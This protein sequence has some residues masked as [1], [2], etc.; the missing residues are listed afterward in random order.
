MDLDYTASIYTIHTSD[1]A[2][3]ENEDSDVGRVRRAEERS[4]GQKT[5]GDSRQSTT[6]TVDQHAGQRPC[7][8]H[9]KLRYRCLLA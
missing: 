6:E 9:E 4:R 3:D 7:N 2:E 1:G 8:I 5:A